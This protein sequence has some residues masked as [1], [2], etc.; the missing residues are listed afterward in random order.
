V[1]LPVCH[2]EPVPGE[3]GVQVLR[4]APKRPA[5]DAAD[6]H[7]AAVLVLVTDLACHDLAAHL[8]RQQLLGPG[9]ACVSMGMCEYAWLCDGVV[10]IGC[11]GHRSTTGQSPQATRVRIPRGVCAGLLGLGGIDSEQPDAFCAID[12]EGVSVHHASRP[13]DDGG[14]VRRGNGAQ[15]EQNGSCQR[16]EG[17]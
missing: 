2:R 13:R 14:G 12:D 10:G 15:G 7:V 5:P 3:P 17:A 11:R 1:D 4:A 6:R 9:R 16:R 8:L